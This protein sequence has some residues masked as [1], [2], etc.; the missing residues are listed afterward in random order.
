M[1]G[2]FQQ[3]SQEIH[4]HCY[5]EQKLVLLPYGTEFHCMNRTQCI[6]LLLIL[7]VPSILHYTM[8]CYNHSWIWNLVR[9]CLH[10]CWYLPRSETAGLKNI[11]NFSEYCPVYFPKQY[12]FTIFCLF[13]QTSS[14]HY[15]E[16]F[17]HG[18]IQIHRIKN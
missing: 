9:L 12:Y 17:L 11:F 10:F 13:T 15:Y 18:Q 7:V 8:Y 4:L 16:C 3:T 6:F 14:T 1:F 2:S 5:R